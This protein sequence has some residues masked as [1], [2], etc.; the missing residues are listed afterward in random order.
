MNAGVAELRRL[1]CERFLLL[2]NDAAL[3]A[4]ALRRLSEALEDP[5]LAAVGPVILREGD[6]RVESQGGRFDPRWGRHRLAGRGRRP[7]AREGRLPVDTLSGAVLMISAAALDRV[8]GLDEDYF[9]GF[10]ETEWCVRARRAGLGLAVV[11]GARARHAGSGTFGAASPER[12]YYAARNHLRAAERLA[13]RAVPARWLRE[14]WIVALN[15]AHALTQ[16]QVARWEGVRAVL[17]GA[18]DFRRRRF[19]PRR[20]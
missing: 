7:Q 2:N 16:R 10:E 8:G 5:G 15:L 18:R 19:G 11:L 17:A 20:P 13:P 9:F 3:E 14:R 6:G 4:G 1:G 12:L